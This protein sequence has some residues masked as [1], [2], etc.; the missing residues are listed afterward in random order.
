MKIKK[1]FWANWSPPILGI[2]VSFFMIR[3][4][5]KVIGRLSLV[6]WWEKDVWKF[7]TLSN[8]DVIISQNGTPDTDKSYDG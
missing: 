3:K 4:R 7:K 8:V 2:E 5:K 1:A 6:Y